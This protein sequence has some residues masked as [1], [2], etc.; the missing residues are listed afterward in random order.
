MDNDETPPIPPSPLL[1]DDDFNDFDDAY[2]PDVYKSD[3]FD[4]SGDPSDLPPAQTTPREAKPGGARERHQRRKQQAT[5]KPAAVSRPQIRPPQEFRL[6]TI[7]IPRSVGMLLAAGGAVLFVVLVILFLASLRPSV[8]E[9]T[10]NALWLGTE[11]TYEQRTDEEI[12][13]LVQNLRDRKIGTIYAWVSYLQFDGTWRAQ[14]QFENVKS[15]AERFKAAYPESLLVGWVSLPT[16][17]ADRVTNRINDVGLQEEVASFSKR[18]ID[19]FGFEGIFLNAEP[20]W[21]GDQDFLALLRAVRATIGIETPLSAAIPPD[22]SPTNSNIPLPPLIEPGTEWEKSYKQSVALLVDHMAVMAYQ[23]GLSTPADYAQWVAYQVR[24]FA[25]AVA[26][27]NIETGLLIGIPTFDAEPPGHDPFVE[28][29]NSAVQG[30][31]LGIQ[32]AGDAA[33][34]VEGVAVYADWTT[35]DDEWSAYQQFWADAQ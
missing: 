5:A 26:E 12:A 11:W 24:T 6:P 27:L 22:W 13:A 4:E 31:R 15:F 35:T 34:F 7:K 19:E 2:K 30:I 8:S 28:N 17:Q 20:V 1:P 18:V 16:T 14:D 25:Q 9:R 29:I 23:S 21:D 3:P 32:Q 10:P 33:R